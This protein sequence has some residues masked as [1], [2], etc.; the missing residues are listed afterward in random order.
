MDR[1]LNQG[2]TYEEPFKHAAVQFLRQ[3]GKSVEEVSAELGLSPD[4][5]RSW[6]K[7]YPMASAKTVKRLDPVGQLQAENQALRQ[8][9]LQ[10]KVQWDVL[11]TTLGIL[12][13]SV[14]QKETHA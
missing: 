3:S 4:Q 8:E 13:T 5:L 11:K 10:L 7:K 14:C 1:N 9:I 2:K 6:K 12:S